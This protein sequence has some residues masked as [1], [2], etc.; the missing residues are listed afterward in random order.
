MYR[1]GLGARPNLNKERFS[2]LIRKY[3]MSFLLATVLVGPW[4]VNATRLTKAAHVTPLTKAAERGDVK[5]VEK[6]LAKGAKVDEKDKGGETALMWAIGFC[7]PEVVKLLLANGAKVDEKSNKGETA[8][9]WA[10]R[11][12]DQ[13]IVKLL[14]TKGAKID[15]RDN[16]GKSALDY[17]HRVENESLRAELIRLLTPPSPRRSKR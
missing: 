15:A 2:M 3:F 8:L 13:K 12:A 14:L 11:C 1:E 4:A 9:I 17:A 6:L 5:E 10:A 7:H 16:T